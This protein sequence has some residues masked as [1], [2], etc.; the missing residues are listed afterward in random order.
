MTSIIYVISR[1]KILTLNFMQY[2]Q[3]G[4]N[5]CRYIRFCSI[6]R[7]V[8]YNQTVLGQINRRYSKKTGLYNLPAVS[9]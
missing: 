3:K 9:Q 7:L 1:N 8:Q 2:D 4:Y 6:I 5:T